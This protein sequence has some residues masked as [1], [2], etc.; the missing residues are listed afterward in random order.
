MSVTEERLKEK[1][2]AKEFY[3]YTMLLKTL[4]FKLKMR[5]KQTEFKGLIQRAMHNLDEHGQVSLQP[6]FL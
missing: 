5:N 4:F 6:I 1:L 2:D 3:D